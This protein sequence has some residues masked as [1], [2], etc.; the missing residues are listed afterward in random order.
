[1]QFEF[2]FLLLL[3]A[4]VVA[5][6]VT[7]LIG[8]I[9]LRVFKRRKISPARRAEI[10]RLRK[11]AFTGIVVLENLPEEVFPPEPVKADDT[12]R[13]SELTGVFQAAFGAV[14]QPHQTRGA[15]AHQG[16][17]HITFTSLLL[18]GRSR[19][20]LASFT[21][22]NPG[23]DTVFRLNPAQTQG[24]YDTDRHIVVLQDSFRPDR[25]ILIRP[26]P[27][28]KFPTRDQAFTALIALLVAVLG[29][30]IEPQ[31]LR[32]LS[33]IGLARAALGILLALALIVAILLVRMLL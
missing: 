16:L 32:G 12:P 23:G 4:I 31:D 5:A 3:V 11:E 33:L 22:E 25:W 19:T 27:S 6:P 21:R 1:V 28:E 17:V 24:L 18:H 15:L 10:E 13:D 20:P 26:E 14:K 29:A 30:R 7:F 2:A 9:L 8:Y